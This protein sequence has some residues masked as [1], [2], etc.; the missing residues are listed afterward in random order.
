MKASPG[1]CVYCCSEQHK[2]INCDNVQNID[3]RKKIL[4][5]KRLCFNCTGA[6]YQ[7]SDC[8]SRNT[9]R[10]CNGKHHTSICDWKERREPSMTENLI[11][12]SSVIHPVV[13]IKVGRYKFRT[14]LDSGASHSYASSTAIEL[15]KLK[16]RVRVCTKS[17]CLQALRPEL[18][19]SSK[20]SCVL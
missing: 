7:A 8:K 9:C 19:M 2:A 16:Q 6:K 17:P 12:D 13:V 1:G 18:C 3:E 14:L 20:L 4:D 5:D 15:I 10:I 11:G